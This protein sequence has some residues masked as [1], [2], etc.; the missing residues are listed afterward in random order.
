MLV[1][2]GRDVSDNTIG[3]TNTNFAEISEWTG[4]FGGFSSFVE[5]RTPS[6]MWGQHGGVVGEFIYTTRGS[7]SNTVYRAHILDPLAAPSISSHSLNFDNSTGRILSGTYYYAVSAVYSPTDSVNPAGESLLG[8]PY[9]VFLAYPSLSGQNSGTLVT[10]VWD[11]VPDAIAYNV[12]R[13]PNPDQGSSSLQFLRQVTGTSFVDDNTDTPSVRTKPFLLGKW[14]TIPSVIRKR[15]LPGG[16]FVPALNTP[17][18]YHWYLIGGYDS[19]INNEV[20]SIEFLN[21]TVTPKSG[22][23]DREVHSTGVWTMSAQVFPG[24]IL[25]QN[26]AITIGSYESSSVPAGQQ[27]IYMGNGLD[28]ST[29]YR[30]IYA[31]SVLENGQLAAA[32]TTSNVGNLHNLDINAYCFF[33][34]NNQLHRWGGDLGGSGSSSSGALTFTTTVP[35]TNPTGNPNSAGSLQNQ[36][37]RM[38]CTQDAGYAFLVAGQVTNGGNTVAVTSIEGFQL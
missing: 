9:K 34:W 5:G 21:I 25:H 27:W 4:S 37:R 38:G 28:G 15:R 10:I 32:P 2:G 1:Q 29:R 35:E 36:R 33:T 7:G 12:W 24:N 8:A 3:A 22:I 14:A 19:D 11:S 23:K 31:A 16:T 17:N 20:S 18:L 26:K 30:D 6:S 13:T